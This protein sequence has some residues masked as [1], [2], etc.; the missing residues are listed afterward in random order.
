MF[1]ESPFKI[2]PTFEWKDIHKK[3]GQVAHIQVTESDMAE[4]SFIERLVF[5]DSE[6]N[7]YILA[8]RDIRK[9]TEGEKE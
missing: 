3:F 9:P 4:G 8:E 1:I 2:L 6:H 5:R 7:V